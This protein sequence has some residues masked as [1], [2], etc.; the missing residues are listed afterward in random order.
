MNKID[1]HPIH[2]ECLDYLL[3]YKLNHPYFHFIPRIK[4]NKGRLSDGLYFRGNEEYLQIT[5]WLGSDSKEK[6]Y[7]IAMVINSKLQVF[8]EI[9]C[10]D[11][12]QRAVYTDKLTEVLENALGRKF[13]KIKEHKWQ[14]H[15][16][17][18]TP[19]MEALNDYITVAKPVIDKYVLN[20]PASGITLAD[21][22][23]DKYLEKLPGYQG[24]IEQAIQKSKKTGEITVKPS[25]YMMQLQHNE[26]SNA[27]RDY[28]IAK[29]FGKVVTDENYVDIKAKDQQ[30]YQ[31]FYELKTAVT[32]R[33]AIR[34]AL[35]QLLEYNHYPITKK[36]DKL[37]IV[38]SSKPKN[39]DI[40]YLNGLRRIYN[41][42]V[43]YQQ[44]DMEKKE[45]SQEY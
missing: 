43:Y 31:I 10:R 24:Y 37:I 27:L 33:V 3:G 19:F 12:E 44:F 17:L 14:W 6:I 11:D 5:F 2:G 4:D 38:T 23:V 42:P 40:Q 28:L 20:N 41:I 22:S 25:E 8:L 45:L 7:N 35:G 32:V 29:G 13:E 15:Y 39:E 18:G 16:A 30:G 36:A 9:S 26:L 1:L 34:Q 21:E